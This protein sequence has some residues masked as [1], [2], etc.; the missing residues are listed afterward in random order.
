MR[1]RRGRRRSLRLSKRMARGE[2]MPDATMHGNIAPADVDLIHTRCI[3]SKWA[4][5]CMMYRLTQSFA[6][7]GDKDLVLLILAFIPHE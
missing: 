2:T 7:F 3:N 4:Q 1:L 5:A 6:T